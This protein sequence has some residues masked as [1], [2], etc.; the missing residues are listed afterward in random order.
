[1]ANREGAWLR[2]KNWLSRHPDLE[3][4]LRI[5]SPAFLYSALDERVSFREALDKA[6]HKKVPSYALKES[7]CL[8]GTALLLLINQVVTGVLLAVYYKPSPEAAS[9]A[10]PTFR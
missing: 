9:S 6:L 2:A 5:V 1:M 7:W 8:G 4:W 3:K 10:M